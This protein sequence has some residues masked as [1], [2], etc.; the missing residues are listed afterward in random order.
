MATKLKKF[1]IPIEWKMSVNLIVWADS[2]EDAANVVKNGFDGQRPGEYVEGSLKIK[3]IKQ[4][5]LAKHS[6]KYQ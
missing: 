4:K 2:P 3:E 5:E 6:P 1:E